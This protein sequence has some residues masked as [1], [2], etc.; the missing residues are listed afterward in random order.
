MPRKFRAPN[1]DK[2]NGETDPKIWLVNYRLAMKAASAPDTFFMIQYL[3]IYLIDSATNWLNNLWEGTVKQWADLEREFCNHFEGLTLSWACHGTSWDANAR[4]VKAFVITSK[5]FT[6]RKNKLEDV[7]DA[8]IVT[9]FT[10]DVDS[11]A[12]TQDIGRRKNISLHD[13]FSLAHEHA[14]SEDCFNASNGKCKS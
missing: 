10:A 13:M 8:S 5:S 12:L 2:Y 4:P 1:I 14:D 3:P 6:Q 7:P 9:A 11:E